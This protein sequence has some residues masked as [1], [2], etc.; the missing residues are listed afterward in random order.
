MYDLP[1][2]DDQRDYEAAKSSKES[3][4]AAPE[5]ALARTLINKALKENEDNPAKLIQNLERILMGVG[6]LS[7]TVRRDAVQSGEVFT[8]IEMSHAF[9]KVIAC[10]SDSMKPVCIALHER[11]QDEITE[12]MHD[13]LCSAIAA[14]CGNE[15]AG[16]IVAAEI[17]RM[18]NLPEP[19]RIESSD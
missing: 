17:L 18:R 16:E 19:N 11:Y 15:R 10:I 8:R 9:Q 3:L 2:S 14:E 5:L 6:K 12:N 13:T 7:A 1:S 4:S